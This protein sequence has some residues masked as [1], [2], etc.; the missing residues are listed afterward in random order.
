MSRV[1][2]LLLLVVVAAVV[3]LYSSRSAALSGDGYRLASHPYHLGADM[4]MREVVGT[5]Q[6]AD[7]VAVGNRRIAT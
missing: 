2:D 5:H 7:E 3:H 6:V 4:D 1:I